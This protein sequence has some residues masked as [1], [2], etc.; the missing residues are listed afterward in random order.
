MTPYNNKPAV[1]RTVINCLGSD[2]TKLT[3]VT[4]VVVFYLTLTV[5]FSVEVI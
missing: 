2:V 4:I 3:M 5:T 1:I